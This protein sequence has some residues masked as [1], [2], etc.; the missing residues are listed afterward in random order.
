MVGSFRDRG[1]GVDDA[2][3]AGGRKLMGSEESDG[4]ARSDVEVGEGGRR[5]RR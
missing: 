3:L 1:V 2:L 4:E 5:R